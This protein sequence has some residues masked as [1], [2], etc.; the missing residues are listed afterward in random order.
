VIGMAFTLTVIICASLGL[1]IGYLSL[2]GISQGLYVGEVR[3]LY[4]ITNRLTFC[5][6]ATTFCTLPDLITT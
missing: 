5:S 1:V 2:W 6:T 3:S 4:R